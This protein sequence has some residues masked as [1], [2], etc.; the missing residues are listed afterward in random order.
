MKKGYLG[1]DTSNYTTSIAL[2]DEQERIVLEKRKVLEIKKGTRG[3]R[4]SEAVFQHIKNIS[5]ILEDID[6]QRIKYKISAVCSSSKPRPIE[7][8]YMPVF[9]VSKTLG[10]AIAKFLNIPF[11]EVSHQEGHIMAGIWSSKFPNLDKFISVHL[12]GGTTE[13]ILVEKRKNG[14]SEKIMGGSQDLNVGQFIDRVGLSM[15]FEF[16]CGPSLEQLSKKGIQGKITIPS[17]VKDNLISFSGPETMAQ[18]LI[19]HK[20]NL[21][22]IAI[23]VLHCI[24]KSIEKALLNIV[25]KINLYDIL[26][27]GGVA[28]NEYIKQYL[29]RK[30]SP[31][32]IHLFFCSPKYSSDNAVGVALLGRQK[33]IFT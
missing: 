8:S 4:Q 19:S 20:E 2:I 7:N 14:F 10:Q 31:K 13:F 5:K 9:Q 26:L 33:N 11:Y 23:A 28:S 17:S 22:D 16:P 21:S 30:L 27:V 18:R 1:I 29:L 6:E 32:G 3:L 12:S 15:G 25:H 24:A